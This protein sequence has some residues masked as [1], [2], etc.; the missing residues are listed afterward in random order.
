MQSQNITPTFP[1]RWTIV[2]AELVAETFSSLIWKVLLADGSI[3]VVKDLKPFDDVADELRGAHMLRWRRGEGAVRLLGTD[4]RKMLLE[5]AGEKMLSHD[6]GEYGDTAATE[7]AADV[8]TRLLSP[9]SHPAP[10]DLQPLA[11]RFVSLFRKAAADRDAGD[12]SLYV[13]A[14]S[15]AGRL[16]SDQL[17]VRPLHGDLHHDNIMHR[18]RGWLAIDP[19]GLLGDPGF[20]AANMF[21]NPLDRDDLCLDPARIAELAEVFSRTLRQDPR[22]LLDHALAY[23]CLSASWHHEDG[24]TEDEGRELAVAAAIRQVR[25]LS[26]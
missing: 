2:E 9:S 26:F 25:K 23:G 3:A 17:D 8:M 15:V 19:K 10:P 5:Y 12:P 18:P 22:R 14:A 20:D 13:E 16:L 7:I 24:N 11:D 1:S 6:L 4:G 21:Y